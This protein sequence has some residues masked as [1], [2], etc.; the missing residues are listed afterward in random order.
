MWSRSGRGRATRARRFDGGRALTYT[1]CL[2]ARSFST[3][4]PTLLRAAVGTVAAFRHRSH[5]TAPIRERSSACC[6]TRSSPALRTLQARCRSKSSPKL[7][8]TRAR[9]RR[10]S[11]SRRCRHVR[12][13]G[14]RRH[15]WRRGCRA[16]EGQPAE[17]ADR[18]ARAPAR[19]NLACAGMATRH[20]ASLGQE[21]AEATAGA[22][23]GRHA[24]R[25]RRTWRRSH[26]WRRSPPSC[27]R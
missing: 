15:L 20:A 11:R 25:G 12:A 26:G 18:S 22:S 5:R 6:S 4:A 10:R 2:A 19:I 23:G 7:R 16:N 3:P 1:T 24:V 14:Q 17:E 8:S 9:R 27:V 13:L 21:E